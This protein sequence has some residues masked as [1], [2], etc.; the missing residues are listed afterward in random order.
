MD[1]RYSSKGLFLIGAESQGSTTEEIQDIVDDQR[2]KFPI[3]KGAS[4]P[5]SVPG[6]PH[7]FVFDTTGK[8]VFTVHPGDSDAEKAIK[9]ALKGA[10][11]AKDP[12]SAGSSLDIFKR[13]ELV[14]ERSWTNA[15]GKALVASLTSLSGS[16][17]T[18]RR[19]DGRTFQYDIKKL[20]Q[21]DR[22]T[23]N[24]ATGNEF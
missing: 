9:K 21:A 4:G 8:L 7:M 5:I 6:I 20:S 19:P 10:I 14:A 12:E 1:R 17:G 15:D 11:P 13:K 2:I 23:V 18:F 24:K 22:E 16:I 3:T